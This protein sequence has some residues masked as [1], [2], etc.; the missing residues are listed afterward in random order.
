MLRDIDFLDI[1]NIEVFQG[2]MASVIYNWQ[3][4][5]IRAFATLFSAIKAGI[6]NYYLHAG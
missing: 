6:E 4:Y 2:A 5:E 3:K 1:F